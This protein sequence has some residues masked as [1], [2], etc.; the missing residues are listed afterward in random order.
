MKFVDAFPLPS[1]NGRWIDA[2]FALAIAA[3]VE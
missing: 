3:D 2:V 1:P